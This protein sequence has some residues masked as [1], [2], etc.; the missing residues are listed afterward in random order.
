MMQKLDERFA[1]GMKGDKILFVKYSICMFKFVCSMYVCMYKY[2][3]TH[4]LQ[5]NFGASGK[6]LRPV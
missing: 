6:N 4:I 5:I 2:T 1:S 3:Q